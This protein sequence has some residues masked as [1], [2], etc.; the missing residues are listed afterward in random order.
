MMKTMAAALL[1]D[2]GPASCAAPQG[3]AERG[4][5][6][7]IACSNTLKI[8][9]RA[10]QVLGKAGERD[11][12]VTGIGKQNLGPQVGIAC[13]HPGGVLQT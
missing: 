9:D 10:P 3:R 4:N 6:L 1:R 13:G 8:I 12:E 7:T 5:R 2:P 11:R